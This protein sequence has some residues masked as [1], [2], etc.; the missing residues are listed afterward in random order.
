M[1]CRKVRIDHSKPEVMTQENKGL[2]ESLWALR[3][4]NKITGLR[5][6]KRVSKNSWECRIRKWVK[7]AQGKKMDQGCSKR[8]K[9][10][11]G[12]HKQCNRL[13]KSKVAWV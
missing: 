7:D 13:R 12:A 11:K 8:K 2:V 4:K 6:P 1:R 3:M 5:K 10:D 9:W